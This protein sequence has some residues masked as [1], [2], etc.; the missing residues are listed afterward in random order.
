MTDYKKARREMCVFKQIYEYK[1]IV[2]N[3]E[4][5]DYII[6]PFKYVEK[7][8]F[9]R[10]VKR[11][12]V[13]QA[14]ERTNYYILQS[15]NFVLKKSVNE[16]AKD[17]SGDVHMIKWEGRTLFDRI[18]SYLDIVSVQLICD[19]FE[20]DEFLVEWKDE[21]NNEYANELQNVTVNDDGNLNVYIG[22]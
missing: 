10:I 8:S 2:L 12:S 1:K 16:C 21:E 4:N 5:L 3:F 11:E 7:F 20:S 15:L 22:K 18:L 6:I 9:K 17:F 14:N 13:T 19:G